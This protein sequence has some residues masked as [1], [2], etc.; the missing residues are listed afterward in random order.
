M[1]R[2]LCTMSLASNL[3]LL[4]HIRRNERHLATSLATTS[5]RIDELNC[6]SMESEGW[7]RPPFL[8][9]VAEDNLMGSTTL[10]LLEL[11]D[12]AKAPAKLANRCR[13]LRELVRIEA[14]HETWQ[15]LKSSCPC[16]LSRSLACP[17]KTWPCL[18]RSA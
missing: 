8:Q 10:S 5:P 9:H 1:M 3:W 4:S 17:Q 12:T 6:Q 14:F 15:I 13:K 16:R 7:Q 11:C 18:V 2:L